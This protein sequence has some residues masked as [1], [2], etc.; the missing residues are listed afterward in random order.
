MIEQSWIDNI[1]K[2]LQSMDINLDTD[3]LAFGPDRLNSKVAEVRKHLS[4]TENL[5]LEISH[6]LQKFKRDL[7]LAKTDFSIEKTRLMSEDPYVRSGRSQPER[8][9]LAE[10]RLVDK[11][12]AINSLDIT[13]QDLEAIDKVVKAKRADLKDIQNRLKDQLKLC[14]EQIG[15]G[16]RW[17]KSDIK[18]LQEFNDRYETPPMVV[19][20]DSL[21]VPE[22]KPLP[23]STNDVNDIDNFFNAP[24][25]EAIKQPH[26]VQDLDL[27][28]LFKDI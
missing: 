15:L 5:F 4:R 11:T 24:I 6:N 9:V 28:D 14:Q 1:F 2:D 12:K 17:G 8:E 13:I 10:Q 19:S 20:N 21:P 26:K 23:A 22:P 25:E 7:L 27:D 3:P 18:I 16:Q